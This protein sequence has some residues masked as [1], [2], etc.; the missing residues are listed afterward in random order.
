MSASELI[1]S[2]TLV[3]LAIMHS[4]I[5]ELR[6][7]R[8]LLRQEWDLGLPRAS[9]EEL[10]RYTWHLL[11][12][13][14]VA[15]AAGVLGVSPLVGILLVA[16]PAWLGL[17][18]RMPSHPAWPLFL[19]TICASLIALDWFPTSLLAGLGLVS[20]LT[21]GC[22]SGLHVY[23]SA[24]GRWLSDAAIPT[25]QDG[26]RPFSPSRAVTLMVAGGLSLFGAAVGA[27]ALGVGPPTLRWVVGAGAGVF[28][29]RAAGDGRFVGFTK[30][31]RGTAFAKADDLWFTPAC[32]L[33]AFG[34]IS[35]LLA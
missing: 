23:W 2:S 9:A 31:V 17:I 28:L 15:L 6:V 22:L 32:V 30:T 7:V 5:G 8:P 14:W 12:V 20:A 18:V 16:V 10:V 27:R 26:K 33:L 1:V 24:G 11:S 21:F 3:A 19:L 25:D 29:L 13:A 34:S 35:A 4:T